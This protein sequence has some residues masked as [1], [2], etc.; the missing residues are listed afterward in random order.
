[1]VMGVVLIS[2]FKVL[3]LIFPI[4]IDLLW[5]DDML[6]VQVALNLPRPPPPEMPESLKKKLA[7]QGVAH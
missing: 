4:Y 6:C 7:A 3:G 1:M 5:L 2:F